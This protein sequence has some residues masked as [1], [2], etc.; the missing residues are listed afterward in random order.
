MLNY[1]ISSVFEPIELKTRDSIPWIDIT[2]DSIKSDNH[3]SK[4]ENQFLLTSRFLSVVLFERTYLSKNPF[5][6][7]HWGNEFNRGTILF[8]VYGWE[9]WDKRKCRFASR[10]FSYRK[11]PTVA[12]IFILS[13]IN[14]RGTH[15]FCQI[16]HL[17]PRVPQYLPPFARFPLHFFTFAKFLLCSH[18]PK[19]NSSTFVS[20]F[21]TLTCVRLEY[22]HKNAS[23]RKS[24]K[25]STSIAIFRSPQNS[26]GRPKQ[27][28]QTTEKGTNL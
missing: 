22:K 16:R 10:S 23:F 13:N 5:Q 1:L 4:D 28:N 26:Y 7:H 18:F 17:Q 15:D 3:I 19:K 9:I 6:L 25:T 8:E 20:D 21:W 27:M 24:G 11:Y 12:N 2:F 14:R